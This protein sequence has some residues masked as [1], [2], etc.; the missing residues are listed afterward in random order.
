M[1]QFLL[2]RKQM[3]NMVVIMFV[4]GTK[5]RLLSLGEEEGR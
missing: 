3:K 1:W 2:N 4:V 5:R